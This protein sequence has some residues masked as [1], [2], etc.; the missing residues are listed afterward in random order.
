MKKSIAAILVLTM[1]LTMAS[2]A[3]AASYAT[4]KLDRGTGMYAGTATKTSGIGAASVVSPNSG[5]NTTALFQATTRKKDGTNASNTTRFQ[6]LGTV[7][8]TTK[9]DG[10]GDALLRTGYEYKLRIA[11]RSNSPVTSKAETH[12]NWEP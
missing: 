4:T 9:Y 5:S 3:T 2:V 8:M 1:I 12:G 10:N 11:H 6:G 7:T